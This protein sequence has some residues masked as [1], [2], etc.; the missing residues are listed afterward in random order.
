MVSIILGLKVLF[1]LRGVQ[2]SAQQF[3]LF[4]RS[5]VSVI[6]VAATEE[7]MAHL[8]SSV[9]LGQWAQVGVSVS[10]VSKNYTAES[11]RDISPPAWFDLSV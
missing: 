6:T 10:R 3:C 11:R 8:S 2:K 5:N 1:F 4:G 9:C 7:N